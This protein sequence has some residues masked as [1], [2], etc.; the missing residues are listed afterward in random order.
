MADS[1]GK[2]LE[3]ELLKMND[4]S[5]HFTT[6]VKP[7]AGLDRLWLAAEK[8]LDKRRYQVVFIYG[9]VCDLTDRL[10]DS[11]GARSIVIPANLEARIVG[12]GDKM[13]RIAMKSKQV[14]SKILVSFIMEAGLDLIAYN[15]IPSPVSRVWIERQEKL[16]YY[17]LSL[18]DKAKMMNQFLGSK[19]AWTLDAT[20]V[21]RGTSMLPV[22]SRLPDGLH[23]NEAVAKKQARAI[24]KAA[25]MMLQSTRDEEHRKIGNNGLLVSPR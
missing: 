21:R 20:H 2:T 9:G 16:E 4:E 3:I 8:E 25:L 11:H 22:Y 13:D 1:R 18:Q 23:P 17:L 5:T 10:Y 24:K 15:R 12:I 14:G 19:T 7:G 6:I